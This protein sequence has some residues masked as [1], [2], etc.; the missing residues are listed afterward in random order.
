MYKF[1]GKKGRLYQIDPEE[2]IMKLN[3]KCPKGTVDDTF[4][5]GNTPAEAK[6][7]YNRIQKEKKTKER[8]KKRTKDAIKKSKVAGK[9]I[10]KI[11]DPSLKLNVDNVKSLI[12]K[13]KSEKKNGKVSKE[14]YKEFQ[15]AVKDLKTRT[16]SVPNNQVKKP[17]EKQKSI[18]SNNIINKLTKKYPELKNYDTSNANL[19]N[20]LSR[21]Y[22]NKLPANIKTKI[23]SIKSKLEKMTSKSSFDDIDESIFNLED[24]LENTGYDKKLSMYSVNELYKTKTGYTGS[25]VTLTK[26]DLKK[27][28]E[29]R[30]NEPESVKS[31]ISNSNNIINNDKDIKDSL[32]KYTSE[33][34]KYITPTL[35]NDNAPLFDTAFSIPIINNIDR[36]F[37]Q[38]IVSSNITSWRGVGQK[39][40]ERILSSLGVDNLSNAIGKEITQPIFMS[41]TRSEEV[42]KGFSGKN[43]FVYKINIP[44]GSKALALDDTSLVPNEYEVLLNRD[45]KLRID[46]IDESSNP[47]VVTVTYKG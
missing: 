11:L 45:S 1:L 8:D 21:D 25:M 5:C 36:A 35:V 13:V 47:P 15:V 4:K 18:T 16:S 33:A 2:I 34:Y 6:K 10:K 29:Y 12:D 14:T 28:K 20:E 30:N 17:P 39:E 42:G 38:S 3:W 7:N 9:K 41:T 22:V 46:A 23:T 43:G 19:V 31:F 24:E 32:V 44:K 26:N 37:E 40:L 27:A